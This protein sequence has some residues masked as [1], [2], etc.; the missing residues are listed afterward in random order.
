[1]KKYAIVVLLAFGSFAASPAFASVCI[2]QS[3]GNGGA[4][5]DTIYSVICD[6]KSVNEK[7]LTETIQK[8]LSNGYKILGQSSSAASIIYTLVK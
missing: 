6:G 1:V 4:T 5:T 2:V 7:G 3:E 8:Y